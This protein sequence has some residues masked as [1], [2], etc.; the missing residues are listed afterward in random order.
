MVSTSILEYVVAH[1]RYPQLMYLSYISESGIIGIGYRI[2][3]FSASMSYA[4]E[5]PFTESV[6][7]VHLSGP[8]DVAQEISKF[9][10]AEYPLALIY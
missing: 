3:F 6:R 7:I 8:S 1:C 10:K 9:D 2:V 4:K 5:K